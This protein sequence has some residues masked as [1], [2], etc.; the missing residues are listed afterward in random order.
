[1]VMS[2][3]RLNFMGLYPTLGCHDTQN[4]LRHKYN[5]QTKPIRPISMDGLTK[6]HFLGRLRHERL[7]SNQMV[8]Q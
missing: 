1:M 6:P 2:G 4:V 7:T 8:G 3:R 5:R